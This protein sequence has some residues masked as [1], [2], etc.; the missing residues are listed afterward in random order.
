MQV[1]NTAEQPIA[2]L[3]AAGDVV[4]GTMGDLYTGGQTYNWALTSGVQA[5]RA[6]AAELAK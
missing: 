5:G 2:G 3:Y 4:G 6:V 1:L